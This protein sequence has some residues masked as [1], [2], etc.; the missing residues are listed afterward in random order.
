MGTACD[1]QPYSFYLGGKRTY[2]GLPNNPNYELPALDGSLCDTL[3][4]WNQT[5]S[6]GIANNQSKFFV[7]YH[8]AWQTALIIAEGLS[9]KNYSL[10]IVDI[11]GKEIFSENGSLALPSEAGGLYYTK[12]FHCEKLCSG[13][14]MV[15]FE[16]ER[17]RLVKRMVVE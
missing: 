1:F 3:G 7:F 11:S 5:N 10:H 9:G 6:S 4:L 14:Y 16:T 2:W 17:E 12:D 8:P 13:V 15:L